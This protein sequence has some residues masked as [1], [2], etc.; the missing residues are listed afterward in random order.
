MEIRD[1]NE[2]FQFAQ[3]YRSSRWVFR[4]VANS[5]Y[6]PTPKA[7]RFQ[8]LDDERLFRHFMREAVALGDRLPQNDWEWLALAQHHGLA[9]RLLDWTE[10]ALVAVFFAVDSHPE[11]DGAVYSFHT[12]ELVRHNELSTTSPFSV[13]KVGRYRPYHVTA[14]LRAQ[15]GLFT[16]HPKSIPILSEGEHLHKAIIP[17]S[18]KNKLRWNLSRFGFNHATIFP[19]LDGLAAH[20]HWSYTE[21]DPSEEPIA[22]W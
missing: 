6:L 3:H 14:R 2:L 8:E 18:A 7:Y 13:D 11:D 19:D 12:D 16:I 10:N 17:A 4:G 5:T 1:F 15:R 20:L 9:T 21:Q 22:P